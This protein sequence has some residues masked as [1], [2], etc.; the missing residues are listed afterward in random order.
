MALAALSDSSGRM[1][2][3]IILK[4]DADVSLAVVAANAK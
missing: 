2:Y 4:T 3:W 1:L